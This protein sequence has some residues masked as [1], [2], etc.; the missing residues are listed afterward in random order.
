[1]ATSFSSIRSRRVAVTTVPHRKTCLLLL[2]WMSKSSSWISYDLNGEAF[3][4][5]WCG[6]QHQ[7][8]SGQLGARRE[9]V[10]STATIITSPS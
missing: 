2:Q 7:I 10:R 5:L 9:I 8:F 1:M 4:E 6:E 3:R